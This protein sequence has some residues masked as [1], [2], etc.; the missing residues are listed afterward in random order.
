MAFEF[1]FKA[2]YFHKLKLL[3][4]EFIFKKLRMSSFYQSIIRIISKPSEQR[5]DSE[6]QMI[7]G[8]FVNLFKKKSAVFGDIKAG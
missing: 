3:F 8:W 6:V 1:F 7:L 4:L 2:L 5:E